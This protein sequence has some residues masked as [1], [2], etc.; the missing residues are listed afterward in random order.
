VNARLANQVDEWT[1][2]DLRSGR[3]VT[4]RTC[5]HFNF[6]EYNP[7]KDGLLSRESVATMKSDIKRFFAEVTP[8]GGRMIFVAYNYT[9]N[10]RLTALG[11]VEVCSQ[12]LIKA[13]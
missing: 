7:G 11:F 10:K 12:K 1:L 2:R 13:E 6:T 3:S 9:E 4:N 8:P 5:H